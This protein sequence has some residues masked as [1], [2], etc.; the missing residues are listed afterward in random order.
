MTSASSSQNPV[1][2]QGGN[3]DIDFIEFHPLFNYVEYDLA[4]LGLKNI[5][6]A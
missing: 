6:Q 4:I 1:G 3:L 5:I 2:Q